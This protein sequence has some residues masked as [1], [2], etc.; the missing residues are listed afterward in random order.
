MKIKSV[1][2]NESDG[3]VFVFTGRDY[4]YNDGELIVKTNKECLNRLSDIAELCFNEE[5]GE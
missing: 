2:F 1:N 4:F 3:V 5:E